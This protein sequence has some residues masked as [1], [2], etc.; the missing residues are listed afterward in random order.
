MTC[1]D[2]DDC[3]FVGIKTPPDVHEIHI[4]IAAPNQIQ[5]FRQFCKDN[6]W[7]AIILDLATTKLDV[8]ITARF[9]G[10]HDDAL[11][12]C[13]DI[14]LTALDAGYQI[15]RRKIETS[16]TNPEATKAGG[17]AY[18]ES[19]LSIVVDNAEQIQLLRN[20]PIVQELAHVS[21][22]LFKEKV[23]MVTVRSYDCINLEHIVKVHKIKTA[24]KNSQFKVN[25]VINEF[26]WFDTNVEHDKEW[27]SGKNS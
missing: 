26:C 27:L 3:P 4:T 23:I 20:I 24:I 25:R 17:D 10:E 8:M 13:N 5:L 16:L 7:K 22:N 18:F 12:F 6:G 1:I 21:R 19:H 14:A 15:L 2:C 9:R 11:E